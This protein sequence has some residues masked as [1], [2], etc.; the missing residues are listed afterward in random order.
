MLMLVIY[1]IYGLMVV[2]I[3][4]QSGERY[5]KEFIAGI[6]LIIV[7]L[8][9]MPQ[10]ENINYRRPIENYYAALT[11]LRLHGGVGEEHLRPAFQ[12]L[13][14]AIGKKVGWT[15][16]PEMRLGNGL[17][18]DGTLRDEYV[19]RG[20]WEAKDTSDDLETEIKKKT[21]LGYPLTNIVFEDTHRAVLFQGGL[22]VREIIL[23]DKQAL[24]E[25]LAAFFSYA[26]PNI[27]HFEEAVVEFKSHIPELAN[28]ALEIINS[29]RVTNNE[30]ITAFTKFHELCQKSI[31]PRIS[32][33]Q[34]DEMLV[35]HLL[36]ERLFRTIFDNQNFSRRNAIA[37]DIENVID[38]LTSRS[39]SRDGFLK[40]L[41]RFYIAIEGAARGLS[42]FNEK[43][44]FLNNVYERFFQ[45]FSIRQADT[46]GIVY[47]PQEIVDFMCASVD[48]LLRSE[49][50]KS[51]STPGVM[52]LD[53]CVG[54]GN[55]I[56]NML[57]RISRCEL[58]G[59]YAEDLFCNEIMLL[60]YYIASMNIEHEY[61]QLTG[62]YKPFDGICFTDTLEL[63]EFDQTSFSFSEENSV[64][65]KRE[66]DAQITVIIGNPPYN[67]GQQSENDNNKNRQYPV[68]DDRIKRTYAKD[69][70]ATNRNALSDAYVKFFRWATDRLEGRNGIVCFVSNNSFVDQI[71]F[72]GMR[73]HLLRD[74]TAIYHLDLHGNVRKNP[75]LSGST[76][77]VFGIQVGVGITIA[78]QHS[79]HQKRKLHYLRVPEFWTAREK[80]NY[81]A[82]TV[83]IKDVAW[84]TY[85]PNDEKYW[86]T[87]G[88]QT[89]FTSF[90]PIG[91]KE[92]KAAKKREVHTIFQQY[93]RGVATSRD[94]WAYD[95][96]CKKLAE[97]MRRII[98]AYNQQVDRWQRRDDIGADVDYFVDYDDKRLKW[99][100]TLKNS[101]KRSVYTKFSDENIR[102]TQYRPFT[103]KFLYFDKVMN[104]ALYQNRSFFPLADTEKENRMIVVSDH[105][106]RASFSVLMTNIIA[107]LHLAAAVDT[108]QC[109]PF[110]TYNE[111]GS[112]RRENISDWVL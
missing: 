65:V 101:M 76:H 15:L 92:G 60:P 107:D 111:D 67:V 66:K 51:L 50:D 44:H 85:L 57:Q 77:N 20:H 8:K 82:H 69:S 53:P 96:D 7:E 13:L 46:H 98:E 23:G 61:F 68:I 45:G 2:V 47:T 11:E 1:Y 87:G 105:G 38:A 80:L 103:R 43:Q 41:D 28:R 36:T 93:C 26:E 72:D 31:D 99:S 58:P 17:K 37:V 12:N 32:E 95:F 55:F 49:F 5:Q 100:M 63:A 21:T 62:S 79:G 16:I 56:V 110:Y 25:L 33:A 104:E 34:V 18:P 19:P 30:F 86:L 70:Q 59:K 84:E 83:S 24:A 27:E 29:E 10:A 90:I 3:V 48:V 108:F 6:G 39:F 71:A 102:K 73:Q 64:R 106:Y 81:L 112:E 109:F 9:T 35:Q 75:K 40:S 97:K 91:S 89:D 4:A 42:D 14:I 54:T 52:I 74:F 94:N 88:V 78:V 22:R